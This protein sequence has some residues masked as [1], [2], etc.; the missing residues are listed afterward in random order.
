M[1]DATAKMLSERFSINAASDS[2]PHDVLENQDG[3]HGR[4]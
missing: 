2:T 1:M 3:A 4:G